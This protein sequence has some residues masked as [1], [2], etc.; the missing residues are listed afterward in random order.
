[1]RLLYRNELA[2]VRYH[3]VLHNIRNN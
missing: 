2:L 1:V 3:G